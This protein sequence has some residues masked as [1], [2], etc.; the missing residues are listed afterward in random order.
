MT[1]WSTDWNAKLSKA[2]ERDFM[3]EELYD[4]S[5]I[6]KIR[7]KG[8]EIGLIASRAKLEDRTQQKGPEFESPVRRDA[9][10]SSILEQSTEPC[11]G[12][13]SPIHRGEWLA[14]ANQRDQKMP[15]RRGEACDSNWPGV[16][17]F[18]VI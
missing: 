14:E 2:T 7:L 16:V 11:R 12:E 8:E 5:E 17:I 18:A 15:A 4:N 6:V 13:P 1:K 10:E 3:E 9:P